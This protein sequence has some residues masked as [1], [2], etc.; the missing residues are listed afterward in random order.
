MTHDQPIA[1][2]NQTEVD[3]IAALSRSAPR[4]QWQPIET[5]PKDGTRVW[6]YVPDFDPNEYVA[7]FA[8]TDLPDDHEDYWEGWTF[9]DEVLINHSCEEPE[10]THWM[11]LPAPPSPCP[12]CGRETCGCTF[13]ST[14]P[15]TLCGQIGAI[16]GELDPEDCAMVDR[17][18]ARM[19][20]YILPVD[21]KSTVLHAKKEEAK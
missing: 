6:I 14:D 15:R 4:M 2:L 5:A 10:P 19:R 11:P 18:W 3:L 8:H 17:E 13:S 12:K 7:S 20:G 1:E 9:A 16:Y 21:G